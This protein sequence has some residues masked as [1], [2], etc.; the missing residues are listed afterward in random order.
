MVKGSLPLPHCWTWSE[1]QKWENTLSSS[2]STGETLLKS[3]MLCT[4]LQE[5]L[6]LC[7]CAPQVHQCCGLSRPHH[8]CG[9]S[10]RK[11]LHRLSHFWPSGV[12]CRLPHPLHH[13]TCWPAPPVCYREHRSWSFLHHSRLHSWQ[14][15]LC[16]ATTL[17]PTSVFDPDVT[18]KGWIWLRNQGTLHT[19][20]VMIYLFGCNGGWKI[21]KYILLSGTCEWE[22]KH[23]SDVLIEVI[24][25]GRQ[26]I[27]F[28]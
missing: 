1:L 2:C 14:W 10:R 3:Q 13:W 8:A 26:W 7:V 28:Q 11:R 25:W 27:I 21:I 20:R 22:L 6:K 23:N 19:G 5:T 16:V 24:D 9:D 15:V 18:N 12:P 17:L 4:Y